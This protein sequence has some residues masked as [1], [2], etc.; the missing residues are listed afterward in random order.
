VR[1]IR[2]LEEVYKLVWPVRFLIVLVEA[3][4]L[5]N[6]MAPVDYLYPAHDRSLLEKELDSL[7][8]EQIYPQ[9]KKLVAFQKRI[10]RYKDH[11]F[12]FLYDFDVP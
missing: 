1:K 7:L 8:V 12:T 6:R 4:Q 3:P 2:Y 5:K 10:M 11:V 9:Y